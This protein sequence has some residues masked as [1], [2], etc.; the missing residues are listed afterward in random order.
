M[1]NPFTGKINRLYED[2]MKAEITALVLDPAYKRIFLGDN[3][4]NIKCFNMKNGKFLKDLD[5]HESEISILIHSQTLLKVVSCCLDKRIKI[6]DDKELTESEVIKE[7]NVLDYQVKGIVIMENISRLAIGLSSGIVKFYDIEH[8]RYDSDIHSDPGEILDEITAIIHFNSYT[9]DFVT[10]EHYIAQQRELNLSKKEKSED[11]EDNNNSKNYPIVLTSHSSGKVKIIWA[12]PHPLKFTT[13]YEFVHLNIFC[14]ESEVMRGDIRRLK[15]YD[16]KPDEP[17][18]F[19][20]GS[21]TNKRSEEVDM[22][23]V[24]NYGNHAPIT[25]LE[26]DYENKR[27]YTGDQIGKVRCYDLTSIFRNIDEH[28][29]S[30]DNK[31]KTYLSEIHDYKTGKGKMKAKTLWYVEAHKE[32]IK[33]LHYADVNPP[34]LLTTSQDLRVKIF[35]SKSGIYIDELKQSANK[36]PH[37]PIGIKYKGVD[38]ITSK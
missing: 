6:H 34:I 11:V 23:F 29:K 38:P 36:Y 18:I 14:D 20:L 4:G 22:N 21:T 10:D 31:D 33:H 25:C 7:I 15:D 27:L 19:D 2:P 3:N 13:I 9:P 37:V 28:M 30:G 12:P 5:S 32:S 17:V 8:F 26:F 1:W 35:D 24:K 16:I